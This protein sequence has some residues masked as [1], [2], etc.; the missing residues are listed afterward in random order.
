[1][2]EKRH[3]YE[4]TEPEENHVS[5]KTFQ[6]KYT[7]YI[8]R[9]ITNKTTSLY[10]KESCKC[11]RNIYKNIKIVIIDDN[12]K[13]EF[14]Q[15]DKL[16]KDV[17]FIYADKSCIKSG[18][19]LPYFYF[20]KSPASEFAIV[21]HDS[22]F[23]KQAIHQ[24]IMEKPYIPLWSFKSDTWK[25]QLSL[26][27]SGLMDMLQNKKVFKGVFNNNNSWEGVFGAMSIISHDFITKINNKF[28]IFKQDSILT[29]IKTRVQRMC[30]ER[31]LSIM[32]YA[33]LKEQV[34][35]LFGDIHIWCTFVSGKDW[36]ITWKDY[37]SELVS[38][39]TSIVK[40]WTGR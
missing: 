35:S 7:F 19:L 20:W 3:Y 38:D 28:K 2:K 10:W 13:D 16:M 26:P 8:V 14:K 27:I 6:K 5:N 32:S 12:S 40:V 11:I 23:I 39:R 15:D 31:M 17:I 36:G 37:N 25:E 33:L 1:M 22:V 24:F 4:K 21:I 9:C 18:E 30:F 34:G 29:R